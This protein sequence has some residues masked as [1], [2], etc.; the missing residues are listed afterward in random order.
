M[1]FKDQLYQPSLLR[2]LSEFD[3]DGIF[4]E[5]VLALEVHHKH[6]SVSHCQIGKVPVGFQRGKAFLCVG[7]YLGMAGEPLMESYQPRA[8]HPV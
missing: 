3:G 7:R 6:R 8:S 2:N 4:H 5:Q 1:F